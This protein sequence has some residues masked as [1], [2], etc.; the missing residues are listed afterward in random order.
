MVSRLRLRITKKNRIAYAF[1]LPCAVVLILMMINPVFRTLLY[2]VSEIRLP[3]LET[4]YTGLANFT[5]IF[6]RPE[7]PMVLLNTFFWIIGTVVL[8]FFIGFTSAIVLNTD[9][10]ARQLWRTLALLPWTVPSIVAANTWR[11]IFQSDYGLLNGI[12]RAAGLPQLAHLWLGDAATA[13]PAVL[14]AYSWAGYPFVMLMLLAGMQGIPE[15]LYDAAKIDG[16]D[17]LQCFRYITLPGLKSI[18]FI[19]L[20]LE[21]ISGFNS[22]DLLYTMTGGGPGGSSEILGLFIYRLGFTNFDFA[23]ASAVSTVLIAIAIICFLFYVP[24]TAKNRRSSE[25]NA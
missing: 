18:I 20:L 14:V 17:S 2:S 15:E 10:R 12:F 7:L 24:S 21:V 3:S 6:A 23:G 1:V 11:W 4:K 16:A 5:R 25:G 13:L 9:L 8:R 19:I 22:F